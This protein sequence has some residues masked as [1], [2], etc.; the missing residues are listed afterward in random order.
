MWQSYSLGQT[1]LGIQW[2][3]RSIGDLSRPAAVWESSFH[4]TQAEKI[5][6]LGHSWDTFNTVSLKKA[7]NWVIANHQGVAVFSA[8]FD[9]DV[10]TCDCASHLLQNEGSFAG[11]GLKASN[12]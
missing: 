9:D 12:L 3:N 11:P 7:H 6:C 5:P 4:Q 8:L 2:K 10:Q 1:W